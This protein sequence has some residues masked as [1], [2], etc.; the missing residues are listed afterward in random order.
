MNESIS[1]QDFKLQL[2]DSSPKRIAFSYKLLGF[3]A[4]GPIIESCPGPYF[5]FTNGDQG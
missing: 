4:D 2:L 1:Q 5:L 3:E